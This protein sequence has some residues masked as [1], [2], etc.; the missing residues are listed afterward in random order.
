M[1]KKNEELSQKEMVLTKTL[2][3]Y[4][5]EN[6]NLRLA[7]EELRMELEGMKKAETTK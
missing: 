1:A 7:I 3:A 4:T 2:M 6:L 5:E